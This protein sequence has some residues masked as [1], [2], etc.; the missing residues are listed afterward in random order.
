MQAY[1]PNDSLF[2]YL[3]PSSRY[4]KLRHILSKP[5]IDVIILNE[6]KHLSPHCSSRYQ[7]QHVQA[8]LPVAVCAC[9]ICKTT[10]YNL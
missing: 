6:K 7:E 8:V 3:E 10:L 4:L 2:R 5:N 9:Q 1:V